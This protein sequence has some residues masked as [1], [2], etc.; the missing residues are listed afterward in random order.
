[1][2]KKFF[3]RLLRGCVAGTLAMI[4]SACGIQKEAET[5]IVIE[6][7]EKEEV[8][9][10]GFDFLG[11]QDVMPISGYYGPM[12]SEYSYNG[13]S[14]PSQ[15]T[16]DI[17][18][19]ISGAGINMIHHS[20]TN[21]TS[22]PDLVLKMLE[23]GEK[24]NVGICVTDSVITH[25]PTG[26]VKDVNTVAEG[27]AA[28][29]DYPAFCGMYV[30]D[31][32]GTTYFKP[33]SNQHRDISTWATAFQALNELGI[34]GS[35]NLFPNY[36]EEETELYKQYV[37]EYLESC[38]PKVLST[39][40]YLWDLED[41]KPGY[42]ANMDIIRHYANEYK[43]P[44][45][46]YIQAGGQWNDASTRF[47]S[48][49]LYPHEG[50]MHWNVNTALACGAKGLEYFTLIQPVHFSYAKSTP[51]DFQ[52]NGI[53]GAWGNKTQWWYYAQN[54]NK[55][56]AAVDEVLM[57]SVNKGVIVTGEE[58]I[59]D[60]E[61]LEMVIKGTSWRELQSVEG[62]TIIGCFNYN[63]KTALYVVNYEE[64]YAQK[65]TLNLQDKYNVSVTQSAAV[66]R[67]N[68]DTLKLDLKAGEAAL[69]VF[70]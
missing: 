26:S 31:E 41:P 57:N 4:L 48:E 28:Y 44:F 40:Y 2:N 63:G 12:P 11:G 53:L 30:V 34:F 22:T 20:Y 13:Q 3:K 15:Y 14:F 58:A 25:T 69:V 23:L 49:E 56:V 68:T 70:D 16:D 17:F 8:Y 55:Q 6:P 67:V 5:S 27:I 35:G 33:T 43:I 1:M 47:D 24:H 10:V 45:W 65:I 50:Q 9:A 52:R 37:E 59:A 21:Y 51:F 64:E 18:E 62:N 36:N 39:D 42:F 7:M 60:T 61:G 19:K 66:S 38:S 29:C 32:P 46:W 54:I